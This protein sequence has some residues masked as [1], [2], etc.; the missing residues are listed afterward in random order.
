[1]DEEKF[2]KDLMGYSIVISYDKK[3]NNII[4][5]DLLYMKWWMKLNW[6]KY[7]IE[8]IIVFE[9][10]SWKIGKD[11]CLKWFFDIF[12]VFDTI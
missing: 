12:I 2:E 10:D 9:I 7:W 1:M 5:M 11:W 6:N 3:G 8:I 4:L